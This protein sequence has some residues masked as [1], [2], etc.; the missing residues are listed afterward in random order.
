MKLL[1]PILILIA[2]FSTLAEPPPPASAF[3]GVLYGYDVAI[4]VHPIFGS[5]IGL[6]IVYK[7]GNDWIYIAEPT[8]YISEVDTQAKTDA[9]FV[10]LIGLINIAT[11]NELNPI[12]QEP[13]VGEERMQWLLEN[14]LTI[15]N[16]E[17]V[18]N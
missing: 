1:I 8:F 7:A 4:Y 9:K 10:E 14:K 11:Y 16:N 17:L 2:S 3:R 5:E 12:S 18:V 13:E 6:R 15:V